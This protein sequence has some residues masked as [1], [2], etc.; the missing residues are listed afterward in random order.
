MRVRSLLIARGAV[1]TLVVLGPLWSRAQKGPDSTAI[2]DRIHRFA[3]RRKVTQWLYD[4]VFVAP[5]DTMEHKRSG[6]PR[7]SRDPNR[8][9]KGIAIRRIEVRVLDP[10][11]GN[12]DDTV[13][14]TENRLERWGNALHM[15]TRERVVRG[16]LLFTEGDPL[17]PLRLSESERVLRSTP[18]VNDARVRA[19]PV[20]GHKDSVD[21]LVLVQDRW[22]LD[23]G[24][25]GDQTS[26][27]AN[28]VERNLLG[29]GQEFT[30]TFEHSLGAQRPDWGGTHRVYAIGHT[31]IGSTTQY[32]IRPAQD[33][34]SFSLDRPFYSP[35]A[36]WAG[37]TAV[38]HS[39]IRQQLDTAS[40]GA[41]FVPVANQFTVDGWFGWNLSVNDRGTPS[42][43]MRERVIAARFADTWFDQRLTGPPWDSTYT[44]SRLALLSFS[45]GARRYAKDGYLYRF[46]QTEDVVEGMLWTSTAGLRWP[47]R[48][49]AAPYL[50][51]SF[52]RAAYMG[53]GDHLSARVAVGGMVEGGSLRDGLALLDLDFFSRTFSMGRWRLRQFVRGIAVRS[54]GTTTTS[55]VTIAGD[56]FIG[57]SRPSWTGASKFLL[58]TETVA[59]VPWG[60]LGFRFAPVFSMG[61]GTVTGPGARPLE[62]TLQPAFGLGVLVRNERLLIRG[63]Q[64]SFAFY[65]AVFNDTEMW[66]WDAL[67]SL[68]LRTA[69][70]APSRP[71]VITAP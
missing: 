2:Y 13:A 42:D 21:V 37:G 36:R 35:V 25:S 69:D 40:A 16:R 68:A 48:S 23:G 65:P 4:A 54:I 46:G 60:F 67:R 18:M 11:G 1:I 33:D 49:R 19:R 51:T 12:V 55:S 70:L 24:I 32:A 43:G 17:D 30:Q 50:G 27:S 9:F 14:V 7:V 52:T 10:F 44:G 39:W 47:D 5:P 15:R 6:S 63:F 28:V 22:S 3:E 64:V 62:G 57:F 53:F 56:Q 38:R 71:D 34:V 20:K 66:Q 58:R 41:P 29:T 8:R 59:Y 45:L 31:F 26:V 61:I